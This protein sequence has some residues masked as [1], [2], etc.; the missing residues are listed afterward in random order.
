M[1]ELKNEHVR[2]SYKVPD[3]CGVKLENQPRMILTPLQVAARECARHEGKK[4]TGNSLPEKVATRHPCH[5]SPTLPIK[6]LP[7]R[8][9]KWRPVPV[10]SGQPQ[11]A[12]VPARRFQSRPADNVY[13]G[14]F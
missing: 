4:W 2:P 8:Q 11:N 12:V 5:W 10:R 9:E 14:T 7:P 1:R 6:A 13:D 3:K